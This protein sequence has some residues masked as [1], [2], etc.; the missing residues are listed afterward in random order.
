MLPYTRAE[1]TIMEI[2][3]N[4]NPL[5]IIMLRFMKL[6][7]IFMN[8]KTKKYKLIKMVMNIYYLESIFA[9]AIIL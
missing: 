4:C 2:F 5:K 7:I 9:L 1:M 6:M 3:K 8:I